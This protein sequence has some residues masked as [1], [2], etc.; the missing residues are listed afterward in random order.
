MTKSE[1]IDIL[2]AKNP[3][4]SLSHVDNSVREILEKIMLTLEQGDRVEIRGFG[5]FS[6]HYRSSR[7]GRNPRTGN[8]VSLSAKCVPFFKA[9]KELKMRVDLAEYTITN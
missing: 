7:L 4:L 3:S 9:G 8:R 2:V 5:S 6:L 1:L